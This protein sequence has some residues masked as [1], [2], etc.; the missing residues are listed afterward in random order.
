MIQDGQDTPA[1]P[2]TTPSS[3][4]VVLLAYGKDGKREAAKD[5][6]TLIRFPPTYEEAI[7]AVERNLGEHLPGGKADSMAIFCQMLNSDNEWI[8]AKADR[9]DWDLVRERLLVTGKALGL[10]HIGRAATPAFI[11]GPVTLAY[12]TSGTAKWFQIASNVEIPRPRSYLEARDL[13]VSSV[14]TDSSFWPGAC[15]KLCLAEPGLRYAD[16]VDPLAHLK[17]NFCYFLS[18]PSQLDKG[19]T[20]LW[21][22][23]PE[24]AE[25]DDEIWRAFVPE[26]YKVL[27]FSVSERK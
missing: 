7:A 26:P 21:A 9:E 25:V 5:Q 22:D 19:P 2:E 4:Q 6:H 8:W 16:A 13:I 11:R 3:L 24:N 18:D 17:F 23:F 14:I 20:A 12:R 27:G 1:P 10:G 15:R